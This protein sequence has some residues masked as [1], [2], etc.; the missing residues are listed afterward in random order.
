MDS[1]ADRS[2]QKERVRSPLAEC[3]PTIKRVSYLF[4]FSPSVIF[5]CVFAAC[6]SISWCDYNVLFHKILC[7]FIFLL[8]QSQVSS[9]IH[10]VL[11]ICTLHVNIQLTVSAQ[12]Q[13]RRWQLLHLKCK[14]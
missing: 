9:L 13:R 8:F 6:V 14:Q 4:F 10:S 2:G 12:W 1:G 5:R 3:F 7:A 11:E